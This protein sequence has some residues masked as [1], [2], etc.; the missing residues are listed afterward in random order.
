MSKMHRFVSA[1]PE[2]AFAPIYD[3]SIYESFAKNIDFNNL[4]EI[5][6]EKEL[7][8][9]EKYP[10]EKV[11]IQGHVTDGGTK[12]GVDSMTARYVHYNLL[13]WDI[14][15]IVKLTEQIKINYLDL[16]NYHRIPRRKVW[17]NSWANVMRK[18]EKIA[19]HLHSIDKYTYVGGHVTV[20][21]DGSSTFYINPVD[22]INCIDV[23]ESKNEVGKITLFSSSVPHYTSMVEGNEERITIAFDIFVDEWVSLTNDR[24]RS[25]LVLLDDPS[26]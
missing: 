3:Y 26:V 8:L 6:L 4:K 23:Y 13:Q 11:T 10:A 14:D 17:I 5:I 20:A 12:L 19:T 24:F 18:G 25:K 1:P 15:E 9:I 16:L 22:Q 21:C 2:T 7:E